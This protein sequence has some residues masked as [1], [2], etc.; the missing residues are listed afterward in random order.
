M[1]YNKYFVLD[2]V[3]KSFFGTLVDFMIFWELRF[4]FRNVT[5]SRNGS[6]ETEG[7]FAKMRRC[8]STEV[9]VVI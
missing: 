2:T 6:P 5:L 7:D 9:G 8:R 4:M 1:A 3:R